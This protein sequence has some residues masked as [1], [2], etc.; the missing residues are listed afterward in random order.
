M[1]ENV[2]GCWDFEFSV[3]PCEFN[4]AIQ[5][6]LVSYVILVIEIYV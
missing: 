5:I 4:I 3:E 2:N 6:G 1:V